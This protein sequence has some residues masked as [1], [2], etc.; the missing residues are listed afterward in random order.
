M[1]IA[2]YGTLK[3]DFSNHRL[4]NNAKFLGEGET[5]PIFDMIS[6]GSYPGVLDGTDA[7]KV[8]VFE[9]E[10][11]AILRNLDMLE[12][13]PDFFR[14][15]DTQVRLMDDESTE[16]VAQMYTVAH[17][18]DLYSK[19]RYSNFDK[20]GALEWLGYKRNAESCG[21]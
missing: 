15:S 7:I 1:K 19:E 8:E 13:H 18:D 10:D 12:G 4:L 14:R 17:H 3:R 9:F 5:L 11:D 21:C 2:V 6:F 16:I 20:N